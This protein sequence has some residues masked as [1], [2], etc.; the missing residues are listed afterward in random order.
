MHAKGRQHGITL[1]GFAL[2]LAVVSFFA[3]MAMRLFPVYNEYW[4][5]VSAMEGVRQESGV[6][7]MSIDQIRAS[8]VRRMDINYVTSVKPEHITINRR[9]GQNTLRVAYEVR[10][11]FLYNIDFVVSFDRTV[12]ISRERP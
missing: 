10:R 7:T 2:V 9:G 8:M 1:L 3:Y 4:S 5:V 12:D 6:S 11:P